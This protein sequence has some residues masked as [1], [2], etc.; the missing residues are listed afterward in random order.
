MKLRDVWSLQ[1]SGA[2]RRCRGG[3]KGAL[4]RGHSSGADRLEPVDAAAAVLANIEIVF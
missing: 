4:L 1:M 3:M 2:Y